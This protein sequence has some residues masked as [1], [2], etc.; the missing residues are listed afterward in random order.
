MSSRASRS[1]LQGA[2][3]HV[4]CHQGPGP[5][6][7]RR[8]RQGAATHSPGVLSGNVVRIPIRIP[9]NVCGNTNHGT[10][11]LNPALGNTCVNY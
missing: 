5:H 9:V 10:G 8:P 2:P 3:L 1:Q 4:A 11:P 6:L 7:R